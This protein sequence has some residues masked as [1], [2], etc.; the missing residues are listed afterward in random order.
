M[1]ADQEQT[2]Q[3]DTTLVNPQGG[4]RWWVH[5][6]GTD[7]ATPVPSHFL[8]LEVMSKALKPS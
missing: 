1:K 2:W 5:C 7:K 6:S 3:K 8:L 4:A